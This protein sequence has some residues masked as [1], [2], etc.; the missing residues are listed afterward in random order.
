M[1]TA[2]VD[3]HVRSTWLLAATRAPPSPSLSFSLSPFSRAGPN[4]SASRRPRS[5]A[6]AGRRTL[7]AS[8]PSTPRRPPCPAPMLGSLAALRRRPATLRRHRGGEAGEGSTSAAAALPCLATAA[9]PRQRG[10]QGTGRRSSAMEG[11]G[12]AGGEKA[13]GGGDLQGRP[14]GGGGPHRRTQAGRTTCRGG[15]WGSRPA[16]QCRSRSCA[17]PPQPQPQIH[18][19]AT[20]RPAIHA[21][22]GPLFSAASC[23][24]AG[25]AARG[26][27]GRGLYRGPEP[28]ELPAAA[29]DVAPPRPTVLARS[30]ASTCRASARR[31]RST[32]TG[33]GEPDPTTRRSAMAGR[34]PPRADPPWPCLPAAAPRRR[35]RGGRGRRGVG[36]EGPSA[37]SHAS[38]GLR[39][40]RRGSPRR[41]RRG[42]R[43]G[44]AV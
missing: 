38:P 40:L 17:P 13:A 39:P 3:R 7:A 27:P 1:L 32:P 19:D 16:R 24:A 37:A 12:E 31:R 10:M 5:P 14:R 18:E 23:G 15:S 26:P 25:H 11:A 4:C 34:A 8:L 36:Q 30:A 2:Y 28:R 44:G 43:G 29:C 20:T 41:L 9:Q 22:R 35:G 33:E 42:E 21:A 6:P